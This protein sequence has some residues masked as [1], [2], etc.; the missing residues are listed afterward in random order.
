MKV[1]FQKKKMDRSVALFKMIHN[2]DVVITNWGLDEFF[3][4]F[5]KFK[6]IKSEWLLNFKIF[7]FLYKN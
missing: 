6:Y 3:T 7:Y 2:C 4:I 5:L 1:H